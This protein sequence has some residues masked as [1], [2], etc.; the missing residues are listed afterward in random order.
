MKTVTDG[1]CLGCTVSDR[2]YRKVGKRLYKQLFD[3]S[4]VQLLS[5]KQTVVSL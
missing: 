3:T 2:K 1:S 5:E 4:S